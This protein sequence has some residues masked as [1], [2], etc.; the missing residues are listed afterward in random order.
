MFSRDP[1]TRAVLTFALLGLVVLTIVGVGGVLVLRRIATN[2]GIDQA[3]QL[4]TLSARV[5]EERLTDRFLTGG[6][7]A[8]GAVAG[9]VRDAVLHDPVVRVKI[10]AADGTIL[11]SDAPLIGQRFA[12]GAD[13]RAAIAHGGIIANVSDLSEPE[14]RF[15][16]PFGKLLEVY[17]RIAT[18]NG[19]PLLFETYQRFSS[20]VANGRELLTSFAPVLIAALVAFAALEVPLA[21]GLA[22]RVERAR[23]DRERYLQRA[24]DSSSQERRRIA[25]DLHDGPVQELSGLAMRVSAQAEAADEAGR[26]ALRETASAVRASVRTLRSAVVGVYPP[27]LEQAGLGQALADL[28][29]RLSHEGLEVKLDIDQSSRFGFDVDA[30]VYRACREALRN[31]EAH[32]KA[33]RVSVSVRREGASAVLEVADDGSGIDAAGLEAARADGHLGISIMTDLVSDAGGTLSLTPGAGGG[34]IL[35]VEVPAP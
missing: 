33:S 20:V 5:V 28:T 35:H 34:T 3:R 15:E 17:A 6:A 25:G 22:R 10:W 14:N 16:R 32:A 18:P 30:I 7:Q 13:E 2:Q 11:Y 27:N 9:I 19:T 12:L 23:A 4:T 29:S 24:L 8:T 1:V 21:W 31:V 26:A